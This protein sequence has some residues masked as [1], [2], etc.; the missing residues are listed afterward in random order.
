MVSGQRKSLKRRHLVVSLSGSVGVGHTR[1][2]PTRRISAL[3]IL[4]HFLLIKG[5]KALLRTRLSLISDNQAKIFGLLNQKD[6]TDAHLCLP[7]AAH[8]DAP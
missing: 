1:G 5:G 2:D 7:D 8:C 6:Q 3:E 4:T